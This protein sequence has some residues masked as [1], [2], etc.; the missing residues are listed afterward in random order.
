MKGEPFCPVDSL[1][2]LI[3]SRSTLL[4]L[5]EL[6]GGPKRTSDL[7]AGLGIS[8]ASGLL[9]QSGGFSSQA[10]KKDAMPTD[11]AFAINC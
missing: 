4:I 9:H 8:S 1:V 2:N 6:F 11:V 3:G 7:L 5:R 10:T